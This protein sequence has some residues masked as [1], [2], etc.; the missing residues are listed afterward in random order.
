[1]TDTIAPITEP[2]LT[3]MFATG[4][5][6]VVS[7][8][9]PHHAPIFDTGPHPDPLRAVGEE[10][11]APE[12][13]LAETVIA[14]TVLAE[15]VGAEMII[16]ES[17]AAETEYAMAV[18]S[19]APVS[20]A[21]VFEASVSDVSLSDS[22]D[23]EAPSESESESASES[24]SASA[25]ESASASVLEPVLELDAEPQ[26]LEPQPFSQ[27][28]SELENVDTDTFLRTVN[29]HVMPT[30]VPAQPVLVPSSYLFVKRWKFALIV[31]GVW[32]LAAL[33][34]LG[35]YF[36]WYTSLDKTLPV[37][38]ILLF[39]GACAVSG[40]L[41]SL[42]PDRPQVSALAIALMSA[43]MAATAAAAVLHGAYYFEWIARP[44]LGPVIG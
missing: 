25:S 31:A 28:F 14:E 19:E 21:A 26:P 7:N 38:G 43:P 37:F 35:C 10:I 34:G 4:A 6:A 33:A 18:V 8:T 29:G 44:V 1:M 17:P 20:E 42:V 16:L 40:I 9:Q 41:V 15:S 11:S 27:A 23:E 2:H 22:S 5:Q 32:F 24:V 36:W 13:S 30:A 39:M 12:T 3:P